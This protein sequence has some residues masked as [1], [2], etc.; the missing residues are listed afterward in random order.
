MSR[1][2]FISSRACS[3]G[4]EAIDTRRVF[5]AL[6]PDIRQR[7][8]LRDR[9]AAELTA[10]EGRVISQRNWHVT[11]AFIGEVPAAR[12]AELHDIKQQIVIDPFHLNFDRLEF[13]SRPR[14]AVLTASVVPGELARLVGALRQALRELDMREER[15]AFRPHVTVARK[16]RPFASQR[17][18]QRAQTR[19]SGFELVESTPG[20][21]GVTYRP[22]V[23]DF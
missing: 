16:V 23:K 20:P 14:I 22:L 19:W 5:F 2:S 10:L 15:R 8:R 17:L 21:G 18:A 11:L 1:P 4:S 7:H 9:L 3:R 12:V 13:W 6:W